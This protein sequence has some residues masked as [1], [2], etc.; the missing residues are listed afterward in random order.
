[1]SL[2][3]TKADEIALVLEEAIVSGELE[4][5]Q[6]LRQEE[7][8]ERFAVSRTPVREALRRLAALGLVSFVPNRGVRVRTI[9]AEELREAF[10]VRAELES[11]ATEIAAPKFTEAELEEL[12]EAERTFSRATQALRAKSSETAD[13][14]RLTHDWVRANHG[15]HDVIYRVA[16]APLIERL[17]KSARR[18]FSGHAVWAPGGSETD[19]LSERNDREH[20]AIIAALRAGNPA[21]ARTLAREHVLHSFELLVHVLDRFE[22]RERSR[23]SV[24]SG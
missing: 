23:L 18:S 21:G 20:Q 13:R 6:V 14:W 2:E 11:L 15:F 4:P 16:E 9:T 12:E 17:A 7:L 24:E 10:L 19:A 3:S 8:S 1:M 22:S 5:G